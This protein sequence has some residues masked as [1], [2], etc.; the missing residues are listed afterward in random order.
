MTQQVK[1]LELSLLWLWSLLWWGFDP[2][3]RNFHMLQVWPI[4]KKKFW[5]RERRGLVLGWE[6]KKRLDFS[7]GVAMVMGGW[8]T[9]ESR[10]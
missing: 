2:W 7:S 9:M 6:I 5:E 1:D 4:C 3:L 8:S 10:D